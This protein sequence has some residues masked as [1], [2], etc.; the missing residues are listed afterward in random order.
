MNVTVKPIKS[1][2][3]KQKSNAKDWASEYSCNFLEPGIVSYLDVGCGIAMLRKETIL[4]LLPTYVG[5]PVIIDHKDVTP[6]DFVE[7]A[8]G[9]ITRVWYDDVMNWACCSFILIDDKAKEKVSGGYSV[10]CAY[11]VHQTGSG[12]EWHAIKY[13]EEILDGVGTHLALVLSPRYEEAKIKECMMLVNSKKAIIKEGEGKKVENS[14]YA[15]EK[16]EHIRFRMKSWQLSKR[17]EVVLTEEKNGM[18]VYTVRSEDNITYE[19]KVEGGV[20]KNFETMVRENKTKEEVKMI[21]LFKKTNDKAGA[22]VDPKDPTK[23][24]WNAEGLFVKIENEMI[25]LSELAKYADSKENE[26]VAVESVENEME[27]NG[28]IH[29]VSDLIENFKA[30]K[31]AKKNEEEKEEDKK[32]NAEK[33]EKKEEEKKEAKKNEEEKEE[34]EEKKEE[35][36]NDEQEKEEETIKRNAKKDVKHFVKLNNLRQEGSDGSMVVIDT[37]YNRIERGADRYGTAKKE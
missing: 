28:V 8:V 30:K 9:Y 22:E 2:A 3:I 4:K 25:P 35:K 31:S 17:G 29:N 19:L 10:S 27:I 24:K 5:K 23:Q 20:A 26:Y 16:G 32:E 6:K 1:K 15:Y 18:Q 33:E 34:K 37:M 13:D 11:D 14:H 12:G 21:E 7:H 36:D